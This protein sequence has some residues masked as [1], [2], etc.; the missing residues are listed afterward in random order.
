MLCGRGAGPWFDGPGWSAVVLR[1]RAVSVRRLVAVCGG[2]VRRVP[3]VSMQMCDFSA[4]TLPRFRAKTRK[5]AAARRVL[6]GIAPQRGNGA[7][8]LRAAEAA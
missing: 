4:P 3:I 7:C 8:D 6:A 2:A 5:R 1:V